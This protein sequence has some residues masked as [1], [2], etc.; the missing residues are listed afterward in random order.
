MPSVMEVITDVCEAELPQSG[1]A[2]QCFRRLHSEVLSYSF[3]QPI[4]NRDV[5]PELCLLIF[6]ITYGVMYKIYISTVTTS[7]VDAAPWR[8][9]VYD[10]TRGEM[11]DFLKD[12][13]SAK[14][15]RILQI[16]EK[17]SQESGK[18]DRVLAG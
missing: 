16:L 2:D 11:H 15:R 10:S 7:S 17:C 6:Q 18:G 14:V 3:I 8:P 12:T 1:Q 5:T 9:Y 13:F 4:L